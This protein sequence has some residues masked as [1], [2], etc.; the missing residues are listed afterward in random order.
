MNVHVCAFLW[1]S[2]VMP[3]YHFTLRG[4]GLR[5]VGCR[6]AGRRVWLVR[7]YVWLSPEYE[8]LRMFYDGRH[9]VAF[10]NL[11]ELQDRLDFIALGALLPQRM[12]LI[13]ASNQQAGQ[14]A[15]QPATPTHMQLIQTTEV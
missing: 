5:R 13:Q 3:I 2:A 10:R 15:S 1:L 9:I 11:R 14:P 12:S 6:R 8:P 7:R 4:R